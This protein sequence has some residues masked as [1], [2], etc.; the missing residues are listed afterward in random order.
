MLLIA[1]LQEIMHKSSLQYKQG[2]TL[3]AGMMSGRILKGDGPMQLI[4]DA[5]FKIMMWWTIQYLWI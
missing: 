5:L 3:E 1:C 2:V 4:N